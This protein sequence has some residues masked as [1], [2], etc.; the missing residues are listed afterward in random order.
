MNKEVI[1]HYLNCKNSDNELDALIDECIE[2]VKQ[3]SLFKVKYK[4]QAPSKDSACK[5]IVISWRTEVRDVQ[6]L[7]RTSFFPS[8][9]GHE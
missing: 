8:F 2:E 5:Y 9:W 7:S 3:I 4:K 1:Y 6:P